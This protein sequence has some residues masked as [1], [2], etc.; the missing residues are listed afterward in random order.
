MTLPGTADILSAS[1]HSQ[2]NKTINT[3]LN[4]IS[5]LESSVKQTEL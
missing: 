2:L 5:S 3:H 4:L 1:A